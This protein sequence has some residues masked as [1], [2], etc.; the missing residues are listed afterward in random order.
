MIKHCCNLLLASLVSLLMGCGPAE[1]SPADRPPVADLLPVG[2]AILAPQNGDG[3]GRENHYVLIV[4]LQLASIEVPVGTASNSEEIWS[5]LDEESVRQVRTPA[6]GFNGL[7]IGRGRKDSWPDLAR[8][9]QRMTGRR[10]R[11]FS[12]L[13]PPGR[14]MRI[15]LKSGQPSQTIFIFNADR[16]LQGADFPPGDNLLT[17][18]CTLDEDDPSKILV[19]GVPQIQSSRR[20]TKFT[21]NAGGLTMVNRPT[22]YSLR[23]L[24][25][26]LTVPNDD[27]LVI[28]PGAQ[29]ARPTSVGHNFLVKVKDGMEFETVLVI[30]VQVFATP[31]GQVD[32]EARSQ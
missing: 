8:I 9:L 15:V 24:T 20:K 19:T 32:A 18:S 30:K 13:A 7:R 14:P 11:E 31:T 16:T 27:F 28:G 10:L 25:F 12:M 5:Y 4:R 17:V 3:N 23:A 2:Q 6:M 1:K 26:Q 21:S 22:I 29:S